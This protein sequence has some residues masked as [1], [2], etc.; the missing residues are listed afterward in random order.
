M[1]DGPEAQ[2]ADL[3]LGKSPT[4]HSRGY[5]PHF[6]APHVVQHVT[7]HLADSLPADV[8]ARLEEEL[9][10]VAPERQEIER[11][12][13]LEAW[14]DAG[15]GSCILRDPAAAALVEAAFLHFDAVRYRLL[16]W[17]V[18]PNHAHVLFEPLQGWTVTRIVASWKSF[19]GRRLSPLLPATTDSSA[20]TKVWHR[21]Y[22]DR[23]IRDREHFDATVAY[24]HDNPVKA[25]LARRP[26]DWRWSS[27]AG[28][29]TP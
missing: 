1:T 4:W 5:V 13:R 7:Y 26:E 8:L 22:W 27:A 14:I 3:G 25:G 29:P 17:V 6:D 9:R 18:M 12:K 23:Y 20:S 11:R 19:T 21:E 16:A 10:G 2:E 24:I 28:H 15:H